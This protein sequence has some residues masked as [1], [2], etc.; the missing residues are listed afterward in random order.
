MI[1]VVSAHWMTDGTY[2]TC[3]ENPETI[4]EFYGLPRRLYEEEYPS[5][6]T[7]EEAKLA[8]KTASIVPVLCS[9]QWGLDHAL[10]A[11]ELDEKVR[12]N[13]LSGNH[14]DLIEYLNMGEEAKL[15]IPTLDHYLPMIY[16]IALQEEGE[17]LEF[18][19]EGF[20]NASVSMRCF[21][22]G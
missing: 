19:H 9:N 22:I 5:P 20:Q 21:K 2:V 10:W 18:T 16:A 12:K 14:R 7:T 8:C 13:L 4:Y 17:T 11:V 1:M 3:N 15:G 6:G